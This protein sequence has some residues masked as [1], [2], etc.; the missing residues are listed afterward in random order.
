M[1]ICSMNYKH[2]KKL[3]ELK[4]DGCGT[5]YNKPEKDY[6]RNLRVGRKSYCTRTCAGK[7]N[8][9][10]HLIPGNRND[11]FTPYKYYLKN[12]KQRF[13]NHNITLVDLQNQWLQQKGI[14]PYSGVKLIL[15]THS[16]RE[17]N[18]IYA[19]S[20]D[21]INSNLGYVK[22]NIQ[23]T[24]RA[25]NYMKGEMTHEETLN[26]CKIISTNYK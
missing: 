19:A 17:S 3:I 5:I 15:S 14:C 12:V 26:L 20:L 18:S 1:Y 25:T 2:N 13:K 7:H 6:K 22:G 16:K 21:R 9:N 23:F 24:S 4:C 10:T 11:A 8:K